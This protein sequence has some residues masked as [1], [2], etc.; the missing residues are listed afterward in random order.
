MGA[1]GFGWGEIYF[2]GRLKWW[3]LE[4]RLFWAQM[5][6]AALVAIQGPPLQ[7]ALV[8]DFPPSKSIRP[9][10]FKKTG[11]LIVSM[12]APCSGPPSVTSLLFVGGN[13]G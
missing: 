3:A 1:C 10:P 7:T 4:S 12:S 6:L 9:A 5:A 13:L 11:T 2:S 8:M